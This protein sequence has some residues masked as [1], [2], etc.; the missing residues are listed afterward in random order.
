MATMTG[1]NRDL[2][3]RA[4][5]LDYAWVQDLG[6]KNN[7]DGLSS[8]IIPGLGLGHLFGEFKRSGYSTAW[9]SYSCWEE[10]EDLA[11]HLGLWDRRGALERGQSSRP[12][13][14][15]FLTGLKLAGIDSTGISSSFCHL[16]L[17]SPCNSTHSSS[18]LSSSLLHLSSLSSARQNHFTVVSLGNQ[19]N[20]GVSAE[21]DDNLSSYLKSLSSHPYTLTILTSLSSSDPSASL[22]LFLIAPHRTKS[23]IPDHDWQNLLTNQDR[24]ATLLDLHYT[25]LSLHAISNNNQDPPGLEHLVASTTKSPTHLTF[26]SRYVPSTRGLLSELSSRRHC[27]DLPRSQFP[28]Q[29]R[30]TITE[31]WEGRGEGL[32]EVIIQW[33]NLKNSREEAICARVSLDKMTSVTLYSYGQQDIFYRVEVQL[34]VEVESEQGVISQERG[35]R[36]NLQGQIEQNLDNNILKISAT[37]EPGEKKICIQ[38]YDTEEES[39]KEVV[40]YVDKVRS[41]LGGRLDSLFTENSIDCLWM[42]VR[43]MEGGTV[44]MVELASSCS[45]QVEVVLDFSVGGRTIAL[46]KGEQRVGVNQ[47]EVILINVFMG[48]IS[49]RESPTWEYV[50]LDINYIES[51]EE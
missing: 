13:L 24:L 40:K 9:H 10:R 17:P 21:F 33:W 30:P 44:I 3:S 32:G 50:L 15:Q 46:S 38:Q 43:K 11:S 6:K 5:V 22:P 49:S 41:V 7:F 34:V 4:E 12:I 45:N 8:G 47:G 36:I 42:V 48:K 28:C 31:V 23:L 18:L 20:N 35:S 51:E 26:L 27:H 29:C 37:A 19:T 2:A 39:R 16:P 1:L 25:L 14:E